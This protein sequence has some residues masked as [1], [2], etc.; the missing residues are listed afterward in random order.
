MT[1]KLYNTI[2]ITICCLLA[3]SNVCTQTVPEMQQR[4]VEIQYLA[5]TWLRVEYYELYLVVGKDG[6]HIPIKEEGTWVE[7]DNVRCMIRLKRK[8]LNNFSFD[9]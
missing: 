9:Q 6:Y 5:D 4:A 7:I 1:N 3:P 8:N 2:I